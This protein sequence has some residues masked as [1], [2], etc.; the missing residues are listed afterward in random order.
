MSN[1]EYMKNWKASHPEYMKEWVSSHKKQVQ[2]TD[3]ERYLR[4][5]EKR[6][7]YQKDRARD[8]KIKAV[9]LKGGKCERCGFNAHPAALQF[10]HKTPQEKSF[11]I[12][13]K[14]MIA[15]RKYPWEIIEKEISKCELLCANC[16]F[17][18]ESKWD[19]EGVWN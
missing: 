15:S 18:E 3:R 5:K 9:Q 14:E 10:H 19:L 16:H 6:L 2:Q 7:K 12:T 1:A 11:N 4:D 17:I 13:S 8:L